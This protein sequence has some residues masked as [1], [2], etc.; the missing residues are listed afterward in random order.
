MK[1]RVLCKV[2]V[3]WDGPIYLVGY[4]KW[5]WLANLAAKWHLFKHPYRVCFIKQTNEIYEDQ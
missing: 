5:Q 4:Y 1:W 3:Y 2:G